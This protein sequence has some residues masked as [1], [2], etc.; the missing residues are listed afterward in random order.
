MSDMLRIALGLGIGCF[1][2]AVLMHALRD[3]PAAEPVVAVAPEARAYSVASALETRL[4]HEPVLPV[5]IH[6][7]ALDLSAEV[8]AVGVN[9]W[10]NMA[11]PSSYESVAWYR[12]GAM[13][14]EP[15]SAV[16]A[17]HLDNSRSVS[18]VFADL[19]HLR[20]GDIIYVEDV[21]GNVRKFSVSARAVYDYDLAPRG[22][23]FKTGGESV[24]R[25]ITCDG[26]WNEARQSYQDRL[27]VTAVPHD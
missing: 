3:G 5:K 16:I 17:G 24:L 20:Y 21:H 4:V 15:G 9:P 14:G 23:L 26:L 18:A 1:W 7:P 27:V 22:E 2:G 19:K 13:P 25:L 11:V 6:I 8:E 12:E 10:G